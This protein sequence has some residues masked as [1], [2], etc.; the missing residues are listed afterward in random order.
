MHKS[1]GK[2]FF[3]CLLVALTVVC[4]AKATPERSVGEKRES[5]K[6]VSVINVETASLGSNGALP[7]PATLAVLM[8]SGSIVV[9]ARVIRKYRS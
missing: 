1:I 8:V 2:T 9:S 4:S 6:S 5:V 3:W 7:E